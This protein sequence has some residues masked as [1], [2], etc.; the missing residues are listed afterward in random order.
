L[1]QAALFVAGVASARALI[2]LGVQPDAVAGHSVG[3]Y[4]AAVVAGAIDFEVALGLVDV[5]G[6]AM[7]A[8]FPTGY[9]MAAIGG[10]DE[11]RV[12]E[13]T[14]IHSR[15]EHAVYAA[16][17]NAGDQ[18]VISGSLAAIDATLAAARSAGARSTR[19]LSV[20]VPSHSPLMH[21]IT[22]ML[23]RALNC[24][25]VRDARIPYAA[26]MTGRMIRAAQRVRADLVGNVACPVRWADATRALYEIGVRT[27]IE[28]RPGRILTDLAT[29]AFPDARAIALESSGAASAVALARR[30]A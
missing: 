21:G 8:A 6:R 25:D 12:V 16:N 27:F 7:A 3:A 17:V 4:A 1:A 2:A 18:V 14:Q 24:A 13:L 9:G 19:R 10:L 5:R 11:Q 30:E 29:I 15:P 22:A 28:M 20:G 23:E 26:N